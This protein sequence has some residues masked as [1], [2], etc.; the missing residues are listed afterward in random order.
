MG[1]LGNILGAG[2]KVALTPIAIVADV[3]DIAEG[4]A[5]TTTVSLLASAVDDVIDAADDLV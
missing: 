5:P 1:F 4:E 3:V 2:I